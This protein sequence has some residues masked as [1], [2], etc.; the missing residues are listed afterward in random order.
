[1]RREGNS[2][3]KNVLFLALDTFVLLAA[4]AALA[5]LTR[6]GNHLNSKNFSNL[7]KFIQP[8]TFFF[9]QILPCG[10]ADRR[11][12]QMIIPLCF[13]MIAIFGFRSSLT[14]TCC[15]HLRSACRVAGLSSSTSS[16]GLRQSD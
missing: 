7:E 5:P 15:G 3:P 14:D 16:C 10:I 12:H 6:F 8:A 13:I 2:S 9:L 4:A 1:M 11:R